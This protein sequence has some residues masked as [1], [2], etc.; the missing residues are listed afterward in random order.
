[1]KRT[2]F[3]LYLVLA[4]GGPLFAAESGSVA[5]VCDDIRQPTLA[6]VGTVTG[7]GNAGEAWQTRELFRHEAERKCKSRGVA[8]VR[9]V[10]DARVTV[11]PIGLAG[12]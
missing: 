5:F 7:S 12:R 11:E 6:S 3:A 9:F 4:S 8:V 2:A 1:M 10:P